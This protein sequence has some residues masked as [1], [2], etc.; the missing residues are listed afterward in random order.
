MKKVNEINLNV[1]IGR[2]ASPH[3]RGKQPYYS[4]Y[5][6]GMTDS[7]ASAYSS[8]VGAKKFDMPLEE[9]DY[10]EDHEDKELDM[11]F[12]EKSEK[13]KE[14]IMRETNFKR[15]KKSTGGYSLTETLKVLNE[16]LN[17]FPSDSIL[18]NS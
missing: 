4:G 16:N 6:G 9:D 8:L 12:E 13:A 2:A 7:A 1:G 18:S 10:E 3:V 17:N 14:E 15:I 11:Y 5:N